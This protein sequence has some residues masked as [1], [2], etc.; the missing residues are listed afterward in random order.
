MLNYKCEWDEQ[1]PEKPDRIKKPYERCQFYGL[2]EKC[3]RLPVTNAYYLL[4][5]MLEKKFAIFFKF[6]AD[7]VQI[8][9]LNDVTQKELI[10]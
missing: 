4:I 7:C 9:K 1:Y 6:R 8:K 2:T 5:Y 10:K 3:V